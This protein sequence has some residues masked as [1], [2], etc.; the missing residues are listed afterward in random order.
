MHQHSLRCRTAHALAACT[1][2][3]LAQDADLGESTARDFEKGRRVAITNKP[4]ALQR[5][6]KALRI[7]FVDENGQG[8]GVPLRKQ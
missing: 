8:S 7:V 3:Q 5:A 2:A 4:A 1:Q 6:L